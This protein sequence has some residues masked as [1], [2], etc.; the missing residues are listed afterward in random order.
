MS[1]LK[2]V[3]AIVIKEEYQKELMNIF[4]NVVDKSRKEAGN[5]SYDLHQ[6]TKNPLK[7]VF[8]ETWK[9]SEAIEHHNSTDHFKDF[10]SAIEG[11]ISDLTI[12]ILQKAY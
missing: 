11:K 8:I 2:I 12:D 6:D 10:V 4:H 9:D 3:A 5:I 7:Y 1:E